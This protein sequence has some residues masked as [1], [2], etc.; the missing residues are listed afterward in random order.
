MPAG[1]KYYV[2][3]QQTPLRHD[4]SDYK[5]SSLKKSP[6][7]MLLTENYE[8]QGKVNIRAINKLI[9]G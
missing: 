9:V 4:S 2:M 8:L 3:T 5:F 6:L 7:K 1:S